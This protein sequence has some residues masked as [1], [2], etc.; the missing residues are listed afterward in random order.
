MDA[1]E[2]Y[3][4]A[5][6]STV[7]SSGR[8]IA[9]GWAQEGRDETAQIDAGWSGVM[10]LP[11]ILEIRADGVLRQTP[12]PEI[13]RLRSDHRHLR[14]LSLSRSSPIEL[15]E[16]VGDQMDLDIRIHT[17]KPGQV[18]VAVRCTPD[19]KERT[20]VTFDTLHG[21]LSLDRSRSS[22]D[23]HVDTVELQG[24]M[25]AHRTDGV[26]LRIIIDHSILEIFAD[27]ELALTA[28]ILPDPFRRVAGEHGMRWKIR[29]TITQLN[30]RTIQDIW[31]DLNAGPSQHVLD[32]WL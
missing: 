31:S 17:P 16:I 4:Y 15:S 30:P 9:F 2:R 27:E 6:Q 18:R 32:P 1:G 22:L 13:Q 23:P 28:H 3:F 26:D 24:S 10:S 12:A 14:D 19:G 8:R 21:T 5:P 11:R 29:A 25:R 7:D 20:V